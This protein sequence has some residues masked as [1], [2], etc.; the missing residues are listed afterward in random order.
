[1]FSRF[2]ITRLGGVVKGIYVNCLNQ[3]LQDFRIGR[4]RGAVFGGE[5]EALAPAGRHLCRNVY[6]ITIQPRRGDI[7]VAIF[8]GYPHRSSSRKRI[9]H[10]KGH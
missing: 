6:N 2:S 4:I 8:I 5:N 1:M 3:D 9:F 10:R 7:S